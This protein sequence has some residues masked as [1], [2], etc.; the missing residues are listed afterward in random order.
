[1]TVI[2][3]HVEEVPLEIKKLQLHYNKINGTTPTEEQARRGL[4]DLMGAVLV[5]WQR[6]HI[7]EKFVFRKDLFWPK[8]FRSIATDLLRLAILL[9]IAWF[10]AVNKLIPKVIESNVLDVIR[11]LAGA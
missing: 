5:I 7:M 6:V 10:V 8:A 2:D 4:V 9:A 11:D 3:P 1:M